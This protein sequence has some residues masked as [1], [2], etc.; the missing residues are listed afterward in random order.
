MTQQQRDEL[1]NKL[2]EAG[3]YYSP[4][5]WHSALEHLLAAVIRDNA[6]DWTH[7]GEILIGTKQTIASIIGNNWDHERKPID[8][9]ELLTAL[10][11]LAS[12]A[13]FQTD[14]HTTQCGCCV[15]EARAAITKAIARAERE[16]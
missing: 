6:R 10:R 2:R 9:P 13:N 5:V 4:D 15:C 16:S 7:A 14:R 11:R 3:G 1:I 12:D 8:A